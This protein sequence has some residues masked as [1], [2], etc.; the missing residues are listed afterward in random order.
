MAHSRLGTYWA[1]AA[2]PR[3]DICNF[4]VAASNGCFLLRER[5][6]QYTIQYT[7]GVQGCWGAVAIDWL[8][9]SVVLKGCTE[10][11]VRLWDTRINAESL[12]ARIQH[13]IAVT[14]VRSIDE[15]FVVV[16]GMGNQVSHPCSAPT[17]LD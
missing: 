16:A 17:Q 15:N 8:S 1:S 9:P 13:P 7:D 10:G 6:G 11:A 4:A 3:H 14:N 2:N 12:S 5:Q